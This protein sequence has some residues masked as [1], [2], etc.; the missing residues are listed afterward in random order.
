MF[1]SLCL[2]IKCFIDSNTSKD[3]SLRCVCNFLVM[4]Y[5]RRYPHKHNTSIFEPG[6]E[7]NGGTVSE[8][9][10]LSKV[11]SFHDCRDHQCEIHL[12]QDPHWHCNVP[13]GPY[14]CIYPLNLEHTVSKC[15]C[16]WLVLIQ[17]TITMFCKRIL[18]NIRVSKYCHSKLL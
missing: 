4:S 9:A 14:S 16:V 12:H 13:Q 17:D 5:L 3:V 1:K 15:L 11:S 2:K 8:E 7:I 6:H 10:S 18:K